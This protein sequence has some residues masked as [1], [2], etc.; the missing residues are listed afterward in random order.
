M[1]GSHS[2]CMQL[3][4][5]GIRF[6]DLKVVTGPFPRQWYSHDKIVFE[7]QWNRKEK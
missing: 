5:S 3:I 4:F 6:E 1:N 7:A 2:Q